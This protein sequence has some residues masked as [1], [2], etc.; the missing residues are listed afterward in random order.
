MTAMQEGRR[1]TR[2]LV[3]AAILLAALALAGCSW[4]G[5]DW[6]KTDP[7]AKWDADKLYSEARLELNNGSWAKA[8]DLYQ[9]LESRFPF[10]RHA[11]QALMEIAYAYHK[12][13]ESAQAIQA[14][15]RFIRQYPN[16]PNIDY[17]YYLKGLASFNDDLGFIGK[18][19]NQDVSD[20]DAKAARDAFDA[21]K[22][23]VTRYPDSRYAADAR[24]RM[25]Y[26]VNAQAQSEINVARFYFTRKAYLATIQRA[27]IVVRDYQTT[28]ATEEALHLIARSY[29]A[30]QMKD[31][32]AD[33]ER[34][35]ALNYPNSRFLPKQ[36]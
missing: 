19:L 35:L 10:G 34:V 9:K 4:F 25:R 3:R 14:C 5:M 31:L 15:E 22:D 30:L 1:V 33:T 23:L 7:T 32:Q 36:K 17:V 29:E 12:E 26:L 2:G 20:R 16:H 13:G 8:R 28:P 21:F 11:Q 24:A 27:Q 6:G 18:L